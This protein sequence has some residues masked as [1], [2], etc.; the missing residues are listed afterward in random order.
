MKVT[1]F[2]GALLM[3]TFA[4]LGATPQLGSTVKKS[5]GKI[6]DGQSVDLYVLTNK[7]GAEASITNYGGA[8]VSLKVP[9]RNGKLTDVLL[10]YDN[11]RGY[12]PHPNY[13]RALL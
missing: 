5:F 10:R 1:I 12:P 13:F 7:S 6:R 3:T 4:P 11:P 2:V 8:I 9:D